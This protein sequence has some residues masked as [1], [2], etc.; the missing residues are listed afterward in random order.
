[1]SK[2]LER[3][4]TT[5]KAEADVVES[6]NKDATFR[7]KRL[8]VTIIKLSIEILLVVSTSNES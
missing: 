7:Y 6:I 4:L 1:M 2:N 8:F 5:L 3:L